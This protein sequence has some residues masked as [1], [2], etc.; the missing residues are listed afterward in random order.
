MR[1]LRF[2]RHVK[3][4]FKRKVANLAA[5]LHFIDTLPGTSAEFRRDYPDTYAAVYGA[6]HPVLSPVPMA[7]LQEHQRS[8][9]MRCTKKAHPILESDSLMQQQLAQ[10]Q[11][12]MQLMQKQ[13]MQQLDP[14]EQ[15]R[16]Q[17]L[18]PPRP[19]SSG[20]L[21]IQGSSGAPSSSQLCLSNFPVARSEVADSE[22]ADLA[23]K[24][25]NKKRKTRGLKKTERVLQ[26]EEA[27][28]APAVPAPVQVQKPKKNAKPSVEQV[29]QG[30]LTAMV[31]KTAE[32]KANAKAK[33][34]AKAAEA[35]AK[36]K[37]KGAKGKSK[38]MPSLGC[39][40][41]RYLVNGC[42]ECRRRLAKAKAKA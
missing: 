3:A 26:G 38:G 4:T 33:A 11:Q 17:L 41:C 35:K 12:I 16:I 25:K 36:A 14:G 42:G 31:D 28:V 9:P 5:P 20:Q 23:P 30:L 6:S 19:P 7:I 37:G 8:F 39:S 22:V 34:K 10:T 29:T 21:A 2:F 15:L 40:K 27:Q 1:S 18:S 13:L 32:T 24:K